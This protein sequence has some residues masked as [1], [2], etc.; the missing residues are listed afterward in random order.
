MVTRDT[1]RSPSPDTPPQLVRKR[2][3]APK[4]PAPKH[5]RGANSARAGEE[6]EE[7]WCNVEEEDTE[8]AQPHFI[9]AH[10]PGP[11]LNASQSWSPLRLFQLFFSSTVVCTVVNNTNANI[12]RRKEAGLKAPWNPLS[13]P[14][15]FV[16]LR[17]LIFSGLMFV[18]DRDNM[19]RMDWPY[20]LVFPEGTMSRG[21]FK[22]IL[23]C[24][25]LS[26]PEEDE[27]NVKK[28]GTAAFDRLFK[29]K[30]L[31]CD[32]KKQHAWHT[33]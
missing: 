9:P 22:A 12:Q 18:H 10:P 5:T 33:V 4:W 23:W 20:Q 13:S 15:F 27:E 24:L 1:S 32:I 7:R 8:P 2:R 3:K 26:K 17:V 30:P 31:Y 28:R 29:I 21:W 11:Q 16:F 19:W 25:H 6:E 14:K